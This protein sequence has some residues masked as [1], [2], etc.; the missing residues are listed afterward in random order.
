MKII[1]LIL[2]I[3][4][5]SHLEKKIMIVRRIKSRIEIISL[6]YK[7]WWILKIYSERTKNSKT[8]D[9]SEFSI[10]FCDQQSITRFTI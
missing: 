1:F 6:Q 4:E 7:F 2:H 10:W 9:W 3:S 5:K 8:E